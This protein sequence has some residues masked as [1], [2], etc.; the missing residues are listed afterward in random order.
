MMDVALRQNG[1]IAL[2]QR[3]L[4]VETLKRLQVWMA[5]KN[6]VYSANSVN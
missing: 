1:A 5:V 4:G 6:R 3:D 2:R